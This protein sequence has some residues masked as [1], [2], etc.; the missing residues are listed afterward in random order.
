MYS[1]CIFLFHC[2]QTDPQK[3][4]LYLATKICP[5]LKICCIDKTHELFFQRGSTALINACCVAR[6]GQDVRLSDL[7]L[8]E[9]IHVIFLNVTKYVCVYL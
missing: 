9:P 5:P 7:S 2:S 6:S 4:Y 8:P 1:S 3:W